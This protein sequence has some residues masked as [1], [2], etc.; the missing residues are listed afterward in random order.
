MRGREARG[1]R[2]KAGRRQRDAEVVQA[3]IGLHTALIAFCVRVKSS[4][5]EVLSGGE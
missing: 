1:V 5:R 2:Q 3:V 4:G